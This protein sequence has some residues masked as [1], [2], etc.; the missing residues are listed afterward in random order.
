MVKGHSHLSSGSSV[1]VA[2]LRE[3]IRKDLL[4]A[5][6]R[7]EGHQKALVIDKALIGV[8]GLVAEFSALKERGIEKMFPLEPSKPLPMGCPPHVIYLTRP[9][10]YMMG[11]IAEQIKTQSDDMREFSIFFTPRRTMV[12]ERALKELGVYGSVRI[13]EFQMNLVPLDSDLMSMELPT[14]FK[15]CN[16]HNDRTALFYAA[17]ALMQLQFLFGIIPRVTGK[18]EVI[19]CAVACPIRICRY[20]ENYV[21]NLNCLRWYGNILRLGRNRRGWMT[22]LAPR[23][24]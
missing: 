24:A 2:T 18:G 4:D 1:N 22:L 14:A 7:V 17:R 21:V 5:I 3:F 6:S 23:S 13:T 19:K 9:Q 11:W 12:A 10:S 16:V 8:L 15:N 20:A